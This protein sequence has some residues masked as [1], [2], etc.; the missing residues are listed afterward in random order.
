[1]SAG[2]PARP[3]VTLVLGAGGPVGHAFHAGVLAALSDTCGWEARSADLIVGTSAGA[4]VAALLRAGWDSHRLLQR[5]A[6]APPPPPR[7][8]PRG[9]WPTSMRYLRAIVGRPWLARLGPLVAALLPEGGNHGEHL[10]EGFR[11][12]F[13]WHWPRRPLWIPAVHVDSGARI[14]FGRNDA[15]LVDVSTAVRCSSAVPGLR[16]PVEAAGRRFVDGGVISPT[17]A[18]LVAHADSGDRP[19]VVVVLSPL[20]HF[21]PLRQLLRWEL[22]GVVHRGVDVVLFEPD[23]EVDAAMGWNPMDGARAPAVTDSAYRA[24]RRRLQQP[25]V[26]EVLR[27]LVGA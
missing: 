21:W 23:R 25:D 18:D 8:P 7:P 2:A 16:R 27:A 12:L 24:T 19:R 11:S 3:H 5:A 6:H 1:M 17:H 26:A 14:V 4:Q 15:P 13:P 10:G 22:R 20:S 9:R